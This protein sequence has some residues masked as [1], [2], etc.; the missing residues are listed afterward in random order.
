[1]VATFRPDG[2]LERFDAEED[3]DLNTPYHGSGEYALRGDY[4]RLFGMMLPLSFTI[5]RVADGQIYPFW[6]GKIT[7]ITYDFKH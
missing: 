1:M 5:A 3:G 4:Q 7:A 6:T 2:S